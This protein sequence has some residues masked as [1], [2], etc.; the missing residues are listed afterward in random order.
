M[1]V[2]SCSASDCIPAGIGGG[3]RLEGSAAGSDASGGL[4]GGDAFVGG[5][6]AARDVDD[7]DVERALPLVPRLPK[8]E[9]M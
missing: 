5:A 6:A 1:D 2:R 8:T 9:R 7:V 4:G 3:G